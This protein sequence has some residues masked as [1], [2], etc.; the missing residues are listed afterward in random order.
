MNR[1]LQS[2]PNAPSLT[3]YVDVLLACRLHRNDDDKSVKESHLMLRENVQL[4][5]SLSLSMSP[6]LSY[7]AMHIQ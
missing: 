7:P 6:T 5:F 2:L 4:N 1:T 3:Q